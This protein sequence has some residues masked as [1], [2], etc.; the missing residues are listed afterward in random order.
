MDQ[1]LFERLKEYDHNDDG[2]VD[3]RD[4]MEIAA[5]HFR[6]DIA[7]NIVYGVAIFVLGV[8]FGGIIL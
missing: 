2:K 4:A 6:A 5:E 8:M 1:K 3:I 7:W